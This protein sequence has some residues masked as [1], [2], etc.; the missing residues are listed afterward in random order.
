M[1]R[2]RY[3]LLLTVVVSV[4]A[5][6]GGM[7]K[8]ASVAEDAT[9][10]LDADIDIPFTKFVLDNGLTLIVHEDH[11]APIVAVN[12][13]YHVGSKNEKLGR[14]GFAHL[15]EH[16]MFNG[17]EN[18]NDD[19]FQPLER[20][21]ATDM[22]GTTS[23]DR[24]N[25]FENVPT[26]ALDLTLW[27]E[28]DRMGHL[29]GAVDQGK[30]DEQRG[31]VQNEKRQGENQPYGMVEQLMV[32][33][34]YPAGHPYSWTVI[35]SMEDLDA[36]S[37]KDVHEW[38]KAYYGAANAVVVV[39]GDIDAQT[40]KAKVEK[41][42]GDIPSGPPIAKFESW[43]AKRED[44]RRQI[45][46][47]RVPQARIYKQWNVAEWGSE[48]AA[49]I[50]LLVAL[51][52]EGKSS[53]LYQRLVYDEQIATSVDV[54]YDDREI[55]GQFVIIATAKPGVELTVVEKALDEEIGRLIEEGVKGDELKRAKTDYIASFIR[56]IE[57]IGGFGGKSDVLARNQVLA[58][59]PG[60]Y[61]TTLERIKNAT[62]QSVRETAGKWLKSGEYALE[63]HPFPEYKTLASNADRTKLPE[64]QS[65]PDSKFPKIKRATLANG[66]D[67]VVAEWHS[68]PVVLFDLLFD[69]GYATDQTAAA[70][71]AK[72]A[73]D[74]LDEGTLNRSSLEISDEL[75]ML[76]ADLRCGSNLDQSYV[77][78]SALR[79]NLEPSLNLMA[80]VVINPSFPQ[81][82]LDRLKK[83]QLAQIDQENAQPVTMA[84]RVFPVLLY[85]EDHAYGMPYTGSGYKDTVAPLTRDNLI[86]FKEKWLKPDNS[87]MLVIG[88]TTLEEIKPKIENLFKEWPGKTTQKKN[89]APVPALAKSKLFL[90][91][92]PGAL[93]SVIIAGHTAPPKSDPKDIAVE[94]MNHV[95]GASFTSRINMNL[96]EDKHW[97][98][99]ARSLILDS[100]GER[101]FLVYAAVQS[102]K[103]KESVFEILKEIKD[104]LG[105]KPI[106]EDEYLKVRKNKVLEL[107]G[108]WETMRALD[109]SISE[110]VRFGL[111]DD[112]YETYPKSIKAQKLEDLSAAAKYML[113][114]NNMIWVVVGDVEK[115]EPALKELG[116]GEIE[117]I[118]M[119]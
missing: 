49:N 41:Y 44:S 79:D 40:A 35:G 100:Q 74:M 38:F 105:E 77:Y 109:N 69:A 30:L 25:Y 31:V 118:E 91:D 18:Y 111:A 39:A 58:G 3:C 22:N 97:S 84:L 87:V 92:R 4:C 98:Y 11:K 10:S 16:L 90:I 104:V 46:Y 8:P 67:L 59:D 50:D 71:T 106:T 93:Q 117:V 26:S 73:M 107:P 66:M 76:G 63:V 55:S 32:P 37:L 61:K 7:T 75:A 56:G 86:A 20:V 115:I 1:S 54:Y 68:V 43:V 83:Q 57:R 51:L 99:G 45:Y 112:Y 2:I 102:D 28:S 116:L 114:P 17:S 70:G 21:G 95:L 6:A 108:R 101:P 27:M 62:P 19:Y 14:T 88:D 60:F 80:D 33:A 12:V 23:E 119:R 53:R 34:T 64:M 103:T 96:R 89:I 15:F 82:E 52:S 9:I 81:N 94:M 29:K 47:D 85:G 65:A 5:C 78:L 113:K 13:W 72:L 36:A 24:T 110:I 48:D 42:F